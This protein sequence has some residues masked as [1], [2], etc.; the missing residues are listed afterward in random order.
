M[1]E[2]LQW[3]L[4]HLVTGES[5][6]LGAWPIDAAEAVA[7]PAVFGEL[8]SRG[9][10]FIR[11]GIGD[12][13]GTEAEFLRTFRHAEV[14]ESV[15]RALA[16]CVGAVPPRHR[17]AVS[18]GL[19]AAADA[20]DLASGLVALGRFQSS[21]LGERYPEVLQQWREALARFEPIY[22]LHAPLRGLVRSA[23]LRAAEVRG[24][25]SRAILRHGPFPDS[26]AAL[27]FV[28][29]TLLRIERQWD[30]ERE[31]AGVGADASAAPAGG[32]RAM[33]CAAS[34][35]TLA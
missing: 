22:S 29:A 33:A 11:V 9:A 18:A 34:E 15:E 5:E 25:L 10:E 3:A 24:R 8:H 2:M 12:F 26:E 6:V 35:L 30:R 7:P 28:A 20:A 1:P 27:G 14:V 23:D 16:S 19:R 4:G 31:A 13:A 17:L 21:G 32:G